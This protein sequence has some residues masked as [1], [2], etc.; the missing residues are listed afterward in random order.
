MNAKH[1]F[2]I[3]STATPEMVAHMFW[4]MDSD[5]QALFFS[6]LE[7]IAGNNLCFQMAW[8]VDAIVALADAGDR[9][10]QNGFQ[11][12]LAHAE[13]YRQTA[14][15]IRVNKALHGIKMQAA[16]AKP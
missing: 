13:E 4:A 6:H 11:T 10:A 8:V 5:G 9:D 14:T 3:T 12:M 2:T 16:G 1:E 15:D 7:R